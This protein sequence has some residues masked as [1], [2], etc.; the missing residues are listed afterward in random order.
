MTLIHDQQTVQY[1][2]C[3]SHQPSLI[4]SGGGG[5]RLKVLKFMLLKVKFYYQVFIEANFLERGTDTGDR[6][7]YPVRFL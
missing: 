6:C 5:M 4:P 2:L 1:S 7:F 3:C